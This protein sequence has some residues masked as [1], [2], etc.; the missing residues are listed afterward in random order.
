M[1]GKLSLV[2]PCRILH[3][4]LD[5]TLLR[6]TARRR[7]GSVTAY[8]LAL[9]FVAHRYAT[10]TRGH[11]PD[12][13]ARE[14][15]EVLRVRHGQEFRPLLQRQASLSEITGIEEILPGSPG[16]WRKRPRAGDER[17]DE[18]DG[19]LGSR[20]PLCALFIKRPVASLV[21]GFLGDRVFSDTCPTS[22]S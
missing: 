9:M 16:S 21:Y 14:H 6:D 4:E 13:S 1:S 15:A 18:R 8:V 20:A 2:R 7:G 5:S 10:T 22:A 17:D 19:G 3:F 11:G 12:P